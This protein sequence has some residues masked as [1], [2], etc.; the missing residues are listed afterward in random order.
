MMRRP[1]IGLFAA[2]IA[3]RT[4]FSALSVRLIIARSFISKGLSS[5]ELARLMPSIKLLITLAFG[6]TSCWLCDACQV[7]DRVTCKH[8]PRQTRAKEKSADNLHSGSRRLAFAGLC[9]KSENV[10]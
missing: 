9:M 4:A 10:A 3:L 6:I 2:E 1:S 5:N 7:S 8:G